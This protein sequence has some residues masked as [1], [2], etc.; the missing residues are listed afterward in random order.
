MRS[1][2]AVIMFITIFTLIYG[3]AHLYVWWRLAHPLK[4]TGMPL[5]LLQV[6]VALLFL[7][8]PVIHFGLRHLNGPVL[9]AA[10]FISA[11]WM[12]MI[13]YFVFVTLGFD[14]ARVT[15]LRPMPAGP[16][17]SA[18]VTGV[19][20]LI[21][22]YGLFEARSVGVTRLIVPIRGLPAGLAGF[23]IAQISDVH[24]G[25]IVRGARLETIV[26]KVNELDADLIV[27]TGDLVDA[28]ALHMEDMVHPLRRLRSR[29]GVYA[30]TGN[31]EY[32]AGVDQA[33]RFIESAGV[34]LLR[35]RWVT[36]AGGLQL[37]GRDD[38]AGQHVTG[39]VAP[40]LAEILAGTDS[41]KPIIFLYHTPATSMEE[42]VRLG[43]DL[44][45]SGHTHRGQLWPFNFFVRRVFKTYYGMFTE[46]DT[47]VYV[48]RGT[49]TWGPPMRVGAPPEITLITLSEKK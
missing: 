44:Q 18:I 24:M 25:L 43:V 41:E 5:R 29:H 46:G 32:Y 26:N 9:S 38:P 16:L 1:L 2:R 37:V 13:V 21:T 3:T 45:L 19:V 8:F 23:R 20:L 6:A 17:M 15:V 39:Q 12:G 30:V 49:G 4:L 40:S 36:V 35:N 48:S 33:Q 47:T 31:H 14:L 22:G 7:S 42:L 34:V 10:N 28:E 11:V 27:I